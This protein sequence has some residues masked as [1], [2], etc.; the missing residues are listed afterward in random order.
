MIRLY[1]LLH[2]DQHHHHLS[3]GREREKGMQ[4]GKTGEGMLLTHLTACCNLMFACVKQWDPK[5]ILA[6]DS[7]R[8]SFKLRNGNV[9]DDLRKIYSRQ[10]VAVCRISAFCVYLFVVCFDQ[11]RD[12]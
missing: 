10:K 9:K 12:L 7:R 5:K 3:S 4:M 2:Q 1:S 6:F 8:R 11:Q